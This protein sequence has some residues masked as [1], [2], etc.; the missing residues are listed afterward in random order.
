MG[1]GSKP[2]PAP[3]QTTTTTQVELPKFL[4]PYATDYIGRVQDA[5]NTGEIF[6]PYGGPRVAPLDPFHQLGIGSGA[7]QALGGFP[8]QGATYDTFANTVSGQYLHPESNPYLRDT[9]DAAARA[10][11]DQ[12]TYATQPG[13]TAQAVRNRAMG[14]ASTQQYAD[15]ARWQLGD[16]LGRLATNIYGG[17][18]MAERGRQQ[19]ALG[20]AP[21]MQGMGYT[22][23]EALLGLGDIRRNVAQEQ[24][25]ADILRDFESRQAPL[26]ALDVLGRG[27]GAASGG[28][29]SITETSPTYF[30]ASSARGAL[31]GGLLGLGL[32]RTLGLGTGGTL[33]AAGVGAGLGYFL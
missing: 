10:L 19:E 20:L 23:S 3:T 31:G 26:Q 25:N 16:N 21:Q 17:N 1:G 27:I 32:G 24:I 13:L 30:P 2:A 9:Y 22:D 29:S 4:Q 28:G 14:D 11:T 8:G 12:Y 33:G 6:A 5:S 18:Y 15:M 7:T